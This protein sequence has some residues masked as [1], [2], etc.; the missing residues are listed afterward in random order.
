MALLL[1]LYFLWYCFAYDAFLCRWLFPSTKIL[2]VTHILPRYLICTWK[3]K[4]RSGIFSLNCYLLN[5]S[6]SKKDSKTT[7][8][9]KITILMQSPKY[10][11]TRICCFVP[12]YGKL[13]CNRTTKPTNLILFFSN[14]LPEH[15][16]W[17]NHNFDYNGSLEKYPYILF[18]RHIN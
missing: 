6:L 2:L 4:E 17:S 18:T 1:L 14:S 15:A 5:L 9:K 7:S 13:L 16:A 3:N 11:I 8:S 12:I 10:F